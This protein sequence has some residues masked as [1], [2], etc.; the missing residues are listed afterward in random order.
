[1]E[2]YIF[3]NPISRVFGCRRRMWMKYTL[4]WLPRLFKSD[5]PIRRIQIILVECAYVHYSE[6]YFCDE[7]QS[8]P[9]YTTTISHHSRFSDH[10]ILG[11]SCV[12]KISH[13]NYDTSNSTSYSL[14]KIAN[15]LMRVQIENICV[16]AKTSKFIIHAGGTRAVRDSCRKSTSSHSYSVI[17]IPYE[18]S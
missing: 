7:G 10:S 11:V 8:R 2:S 4:D 3:V 6:E 14:S 17:Q 12:R 15:S 5:R 9:L 18:R 13:T 1:M 16:C